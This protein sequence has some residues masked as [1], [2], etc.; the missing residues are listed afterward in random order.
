[1]PTPGISRR[2]SAISRFMSAIVTSFAHAGRSGLDSR[3]AAPIPVRQYAS[4]ASVAISAGS[5]P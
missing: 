2:V 3:P 4:A 1:M 5:S